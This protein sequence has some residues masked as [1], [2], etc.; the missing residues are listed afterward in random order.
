MRQ[1]ADVRMYGEA[2][3]KRSALFNVDMSISDITQEPPGVTRSSGGSRVCLV[4][5]NSLAPSRHWIKTPS[6]MLS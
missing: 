3:N 6:A 1:K 4:H 5:T 2:S